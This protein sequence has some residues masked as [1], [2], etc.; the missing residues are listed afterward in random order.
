[1]TTNKPEA[2]AWGNDPR[3]MTEEDL[4]P[5]PNCNHRAV[6]ATRRAT[7]GLPFVGLW[8]VSCQKP[9][10]PLGMIYFHPVEWN[11]LP[12]IRQSEYAALQAKC[13]KLRNLLRHA[14]PIIRAHAEAS[15]MLEGF[16]PRRNQWDELVEG[17]DTAMQEAA[18]ESH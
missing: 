18:H 10:C 13:E 5:C 17:I 4:L 3:K 11:R 7:K 8:K 12:R 15:H 16:R 14:Q 1:M 6:S 9:E 2:I